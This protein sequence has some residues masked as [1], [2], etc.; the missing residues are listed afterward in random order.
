MRVRPADGWAVASAGSGKLRWIAMAGNAAIGRN[1]TAGRATITISSGVFGEGKERRGRPDKDGRMQWPS[2]AIVTCR[3]QKT[4][5]APAGELVVYRGEQVG[6]LGP[7]PPAGQPGGTSTAR[8]WEKPV[9]GSAAARQPGLRLD[10]RSF[11][12]TIDVVSHRFAPPVKLSRRLSRVHPR[13]S[14]CALRM[15]PKLSALGRWACQHVTRF[16][17]GVYDSTA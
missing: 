3:K 12:M 13:S 2:E 9:G 17:C 4:C 5:R 7:A 16:T 8:G 10:S 6:W 14:L 11:Q 15:R 1:T